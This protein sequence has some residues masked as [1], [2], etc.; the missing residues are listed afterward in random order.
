M[1]NFNLFLRVTL[2]AALLLATGVPGLGVPGL[3]VL[4]SSAAMGN[5]FAADT[6]GIQDYMLDIK[7][8]DEYERHDSYS[9]FSF[10]NLAVA[11]IGGGHAFALK[12]GDTFERG[13]T[14]SRANIG[15]AIYGDGAEVSCGI[16]FDGVVHVAGDLVILDEDSPPDGMDGD[17]LF[18]LSEETA[19]GIPFP[20][21]WHAAGVW[22]L[23]FN[24]GPAHKYESVIDFDS[25]G[26][27]PG[28]KQ[29]HLVTLT[30]L[31]LT[32]SDQL[33]V[34]HSATL[35]HIGPPGR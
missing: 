25:F 2:T 23:P 30:D 31:S 13:L 34:S 12:P 6:I 16:D 9:A 19:A 8:A 7:D 28:E 29:S 27:K 32:A 17:L 4:V 26:F 3:G 11:Q 21:G 15:G 14:V 20:V 1:K 5:L 33:S 18:Y 24:L 35:E 22:S 10:K